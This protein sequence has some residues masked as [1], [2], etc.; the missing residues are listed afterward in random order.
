MILINSFVTKTN[1]LKVF[2][3]TT[4]DRKEFP[5]IYTLMNLFDQ[6]REAFLT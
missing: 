2:F 1:P 6:L 3:I 4:N 5:Q